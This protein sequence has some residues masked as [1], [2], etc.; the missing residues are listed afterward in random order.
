MS[1][2]GEWAVIVP[3]RSLDVA[4]SRLAV[5]CR[6][7]LALAFLQDT[8][9][10]LTLS[11]HIS[12]VIVVSRNAALS[13]TIGTPVIKDQGSGIDDAVEI[14]HRWLR[15]HGHDGH[16]SVVMPDLPALRTGDIDNFLSAASRFPRAFVADSAGTGTTCLTTQQAAIL[17][18]FGRNSAQRH[19][20]MGYKQIPL[21]LPSLR[22]D[23]DTIDDLERAARMG[24]G[25]HTQ[26]LLISN[27]ELHSLRFP[28]APG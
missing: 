10:A 17:S 16:Y 1:D 15:E 5:S 22:L 21:G 25:R 9:A 12:S 11:N 8:L 14:G 3:F 23:V 18:A 19:T 2:Y 6:R 28:C 24:V 27:N 7:D 4:K 26:R 20:R 13:E